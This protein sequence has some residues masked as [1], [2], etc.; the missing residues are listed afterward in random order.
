M[1]RSV[2]T[3]CGS[4]WPRMPFVS[5]ASSCMPIP[6]QAE[7]FNLPLGFDNPSPSKPI[8]LMVTLADPGRC[9]NEQ[10]RRSVGNRMLPPSFVSGLHLQHH[11]RDVIDLGNAFLPLAF[12]CEKLHEVSDNLGVI[13]AKDFQI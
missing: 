9:R 6:E 8:A 5:A 3:L 11:S 1:P 7:A 13:S 12:L 2:I 4:P 10:G